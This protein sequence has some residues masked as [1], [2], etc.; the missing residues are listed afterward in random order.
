MFKKLLSVAFLY[1]IMVTSVYA[2]NGTLTGIVTSSE[3]GETLPAVNVT[4]VEI[5]KGT[6]ANAYGVYVINNITPG[7]YTVKVTYVGF[8]T[9]E[10]TVEISSGE[11]VLDF[12]MSP[13]VGLLDEIIVSG[14]A[15]ATPRKLLTISVAKV[16]AERLNQVPATSISNSLA[17]KV[18]GVTIRSQ[19]GT[20]GGAPNILLRADNNLNVESSP[21][22]LVDG[23]IIERSLADINVEDIE[24]IEVVK[25][26][27][28]SSLYG[29]RAGNGVV[30][31]TTKRGDKLENNQ[32]DITIRNEI[33]IQQLERTI[34]LAETHYFDLAE[35]WESFRGDFTKFDGVEYPDGYLGG[36]HDEIVGSRNISADHYMDNPYGVNN[37]IQDEFFRNGTNFTNYVSVATRFDRVNVFGSFENHS[38]EGIIPD[39]DGFKRQNF[40]IN[41][42]FQINSWLRLST[43]NLF[44]ETTSEFPGSGGGFFFNLVL[45]EPDNNLY[46][47]NPDGQPYYIRHNQWSNE[48]N[49][50]YNT[51]K[52]ER[53]ELTARQISNFSLTAKPLDWLEYKGSYSFENED[54]RFTAHTPFD[55]W[56]IGLTG[57]GSELSN[58]GISYTQGDLRKYSEKT[59]Q[60]VLEHTLI[61]RETFGK[62]DF[63]GTLKYSWEKLEYEEI[64]AFGFDFLVFG[65]PT[66]GAFEP[67]DITASSV[68]EEIQSQ[69]YYGTVYFNYDDTF[70]IDALLR[71]DE[72]SL[73][74]PDSRSNTYYRVSA[75]YR[76]TE[77]V[78]LPVFDELKFRAS[79]GSAG[80][81]PQF[82]Y[83]YEAY[84]ATNGII[85][86]QRLGNLDLKP[87]TTTET[88]FAINA[89]IGRTSF[90]ATYSYAETVDQ[91]LL[92]PLLPLAGAPAQYQNAGTIE[93]NTI[94]FNLES[95]IFHTQN[96]RWDLNITWQSS[97]QEITE[98]PI[99]PYTTGPDGL[100]FIREGEDYGAIYGRDW[101]RTLDQMAQQLPDGE[102]IDDYVVNSDGY[103]INAET[104][105]TVDEAGIYL[106][107]ENGNI[108]NV[109]IGNGR[110]D[111]T[112][113]IA[114]T[115]NY[116]GLSAYVLIDIKHGGDVYNRKSQWL[117]RDARNG[118]MD[119]SGIPD[120][121]KKTF[122]YYQSFYDVNSNNSYWVEDAGYVKIR[123]LAI[124]YTMNA[125]QLEPIFGGAVKSIKASLIGRNL[126]TFTDYSG[127]DPEV[128]TIRNP[129]DGT[130]TYPNFRNYS[131]SLQFKF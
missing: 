86:I 6:A 21:L 41:A 84:I 5:L 118:I 68:T 56:G 80:N 85:T 26:A 98:L 2:Q 115:F 91:F 102:T 28:A 83:Q 97:K 101:V 15:D 58:L 38:E 62:I 30:V 114:N 122:D 111:W 47:E 123:E 127:Y 16:D 96:F 88:E 130:G 4:L 34:D 24:S 113:G 57:P 44:I 121:Q 94:E 55:T 126:F 8:V 110:P 116:K 100:Y 7:T 31:V 95:N 22:I 104:E 18:S 33:G 119:Q 14:V 77:Q 79:Q 107:D 109:R 54:Y 67:E 93:A 117:T 49:P 131:I 66:L 71:Q 52:E 108:A 51:F 32:F 50:L 125:A 124:S 12:L 128:G 99:A 25:G 89:G 46:L 17:A 129:Y 29:S 106:R 39:T 81:R 48:Q 19:N 1:V 76:L 105:G 90:E 60:E 43:S 9:I 59:F 61:Y 11:T 64:D 35:D 74:G 45:A 37:D 87:S 72:S 78:E 20:P 36:F 10:Q 27:A 23:V 103:V 120:G 75:A 53:N 3:N 73:F 40:R 13:D 63:K 92:V 70:I 65:T 69:N 82:N 42:D 112:S